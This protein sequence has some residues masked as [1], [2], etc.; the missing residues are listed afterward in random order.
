[1]I[2]NVHHVDNFSGIENT[3]D[4]EVPDKATLQEIFDHVCCNG[5]YET[6]GEYKDTIASEGLIVF[7]DDSEYSRGH[8]ITITWKTRLF[9]P[10][11]LLKQEGESEQHHEP[12]D[13]E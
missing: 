11:P 7:N 6:I 4:K 1:M 9:T 8:I 12:G 3:F 13:K 2:V 10:L 5:V